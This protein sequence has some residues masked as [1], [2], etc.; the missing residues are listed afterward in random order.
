[1]TRDTFEAG[2]HQV[3]STAIAGIEKSLQD[4]KIDVIIG[5]A[6]AR[7]ASVAAAAGFPVA[8]VPLGY[9]DFNGRAF[10]MNIIAAAGAE[11]TMLRVMSA[12]EATFP[13]GR[14]PPPMMVH[15]DDMITKGTAKM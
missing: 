8:T 7:M 1:M 4:Y 13:E 3:R 5:P 11:H 15:W 10:G 6:D 12:W 2:L 14:K 9:A